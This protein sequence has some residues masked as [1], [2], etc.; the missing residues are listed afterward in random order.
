ML[1]AVEVG[2][3]NTTF[4]LFSAS[5]ELVASYR[6]ST[7]RDRMPDEWFAMLAALLASDGH[8]LRDV[9]GVIV[10]SVVPSVTTWLLEMAHNRLGIDPVVVSGELDVGLGLDVEEPRQLGA[11]RI[12]DCVATFASYGGP[13]IIVDLGTATTFDVIGADG[14]YL[15]GAI[16]AGVGTS[17]KALA[18]NAAQLFNVELHMPDHVIG[19]NTAD[20]LR[21]GL[22]AGHLAMVEGMIERTRSE[23]ESDATVVITGGLAPLFAG[24]SPLFDHYDPDL[25]L[26]GLK[27]IYDRVKGVSGR[28]QIPAHNLS[29]GSSGGS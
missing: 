6:L 23:L 27:I 10:S 13:A 7:E 4:G 2:N 1:L 26:R 21:A 24:R 12:V 9:D 3:T 5:G 29:S 25:T 17:L 16:A 22:V 19:R 15:G 11:D 28:A 18:T 14:T 8:S 20:Q